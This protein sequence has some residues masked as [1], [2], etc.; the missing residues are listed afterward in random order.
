MVAISE[1]AI[2]NKKKQ[3]D[4]ESETRAI[5]VVCFY[6]RWKITKKV[7]NSSRRGNLPLHEAVREM[8]G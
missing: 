4:V 6:E 2:K 8:E 1:D 7:I 5:V 3:R